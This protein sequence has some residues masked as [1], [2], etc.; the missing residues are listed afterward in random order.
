MIIIQNLPIL[1]HFNQIQDHQ[2]VCQL[3]LLF[4]N[5]Q[6]INYCKMI[7]QIQYLLNAS[8]HVKLLLPLKNLFN[9]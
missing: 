2:I 5:F 8:I 6:K 4:T 1:S 7:V 3:H 9:K